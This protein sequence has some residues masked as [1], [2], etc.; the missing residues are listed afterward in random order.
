VSAAGHV[1]RAQSN[2]RGDLEAALRCN[3]GVPEIS[4]FERRYH[5]SPGNGSRPSPGALQIENDKSG[6][7]ADSRPT[8]RSLHW[9]LKNG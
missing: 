8:V 2:G 3:L 7:L 1:A 9:V 5:P 4:L 6:G